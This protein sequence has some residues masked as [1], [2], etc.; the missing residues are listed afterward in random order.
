MVV[1]MGVIIAKVFR[2]HN[3]EFMRK[4]FF[5][6]WCDMG[7]IRKNPNKTGVFGDKK[8]LREGVDR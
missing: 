8:N 7:K 1:F 2:L 6:G 3:E 5:C 4:K